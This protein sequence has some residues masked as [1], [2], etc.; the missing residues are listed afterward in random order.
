V[1]VEQVEE[2]VRVLGERRC[3]DDDLVR[4]AGTAQELVAPWPLAHVH[5]VNKALDLHGED[6]VRV[7]D[8]LEGGVHQSLVEVEHQARLADCGEGKR[9]RSGERKW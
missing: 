2:R 7:G 4:L 1:R 6:E 8:G 5:L 3:K 9:G